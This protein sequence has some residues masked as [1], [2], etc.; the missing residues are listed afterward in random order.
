MIATRRDNEL[1][2]YSY[3]ITRYRCA[4]Q[5]KHMRETWELGIGNTETLNDVAHNGTCE[6]IWQI[7][8]LGNTPLVNQILIILD[9]S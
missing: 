1:T 7:M 5:T 8:L 9:N 2:R 6:N 3:R 4:N